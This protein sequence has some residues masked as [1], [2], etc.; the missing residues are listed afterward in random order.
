MT[1]NDDTVP[2]DDVEKKTG[3]IVRSNFGDF[4]LLSVLQRR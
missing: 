1:F 2:Y 4:E 3:F